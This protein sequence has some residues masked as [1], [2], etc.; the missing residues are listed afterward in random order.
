MHA[1]TPSAAIAEALGVKLSV[2]ASWQEAALDRVLDEGHARL[3]GLVAARLERRGWE[4]HIEVS[5]SIFGE[6]GSID[7]LAWHAATATLLVIEIKTELGSIEGLLRPLDAKV[8]LAAGIAR[9][10][11]GWHAGRVGAV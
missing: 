2:V 10:R 9:D 7:I 3:V 6:R 8:R 1:V 11:F 5:Y 4:T